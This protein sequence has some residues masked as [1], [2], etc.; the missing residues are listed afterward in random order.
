M[1]VGCISSHYQTLKF[2][3]S[4]TIILI[5]PHFMVLNIV[6]RKI[7]KLGK[8]YWDE[9]LN[10]HDNFYMSCGTLKV[11]YRF[12]IDRLLLVCAFYCIDIGHDSN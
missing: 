9:N 2:I 6:P 11:I 5:F 12:F 8:S 7:R 10:G 3:I 1:L 4:N